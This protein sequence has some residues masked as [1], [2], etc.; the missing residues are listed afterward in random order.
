MPEK[1]HRQS[2]VLVVGIKHEIQRHQDTMSVR[3]VMREAFDKTLRR[4]IEERKVTIIA[5]EAGDDK[6][7]WEHLKKG[8]PDGEL[9]ERLFG[10]GSTTVDSTV[11]TIAKKI[12]EEYGVKHEDVDVDVRADERDQGSIEKREAAMIEKILKVSGDAASILVIVGEGH[13]A[14]V[15]QRLKKEGLATESLRFP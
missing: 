12:S 5:E 3:E 7:V 8:E 6:T 9:A 11:P 10:K 14:G 4:I 1:P 13:R 2:N 15:E